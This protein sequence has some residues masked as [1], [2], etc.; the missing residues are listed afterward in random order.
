MDLIKVNVIRIQALQAFINFRHDGF[1]RQPLSVR[2][3]FAAHR[4]RREKHFRRQHDFI[5]VCKK[6]TQE[7]TDHHLRRAGRVAVCCIE[8]VNALFNR[9]AKY[10]TCII[11]GKR[12][13]M[14][15]GVRLTECHTSQTQT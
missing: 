7:F 8:E 6:L 9:M 3:G 5:A 14:S 1:T 2:A 11:F 13:G 10:G 4:A 12:P 15:A